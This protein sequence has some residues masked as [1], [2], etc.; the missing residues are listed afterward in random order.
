M[1]KILVEKIL[2]EKDA[3]IE[4]HFVLS[5][6][7]HS[8]R[9]VQC[10]KVLQYPEIA[11]QFSKVLVKKIAARC[12]LVISPAMGGIIIGY[13]IARQLKVRAIFCERENGVMNLRRGFEIKKGERCLIVEDVITT[14]GSTKEVIEVVKSYGGKVVGI[15]S[16]INRSE[17]KNFS[18]SLLKLKIKTYKPENCPLCKKKIPLVKPGSRTNVRLGCDQRSENDYL[19]KIGC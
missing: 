11:E 2:K 18:I 8:D 15:A 4:G 17:L 13:E 6:G 9:Y 10:A 12:D 3:L 14:G 7:L 19:Q 16:I 5:S 1:K